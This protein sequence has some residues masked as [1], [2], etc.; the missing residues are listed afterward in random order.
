L[1]LAGVKYRAVKKKEEVV[2]VMDGCGLVYGEDGFER[3]N[4][5]Q[6]TATEFKSMLATFV[7]QDWP[8]QFLL[9]DHYGMWCQAFNVRTVYFMLLEN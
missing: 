7:Q 4:S 9:R 2:F 8:V 5:F 3:D 6:Y 1:L